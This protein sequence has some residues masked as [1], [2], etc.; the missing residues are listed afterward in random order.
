VRAIAWD[1]HRNRV[2]VAVAEGGT[3]VVLLYDM[4]AERWDGTVLRHAWQT[5]VSCMAAQP[6]ACATFAVGCATGICYWQL[7]PA[8]GAPPPA[9]LPQQPPAVG[10]APPPDSAWMQFW[11]LGGFTGVTCMSWSPCGR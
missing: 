7:E 4:D 6:R 8:G 3:E 9:P 10:A 2:A 1:E 5:A 11:A